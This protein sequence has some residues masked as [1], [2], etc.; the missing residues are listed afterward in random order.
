L[1]A[2]PAYGVVHEPSFTTGPRAPQ[3]AS[4]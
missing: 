1:Y 4:R 3:T 2:R